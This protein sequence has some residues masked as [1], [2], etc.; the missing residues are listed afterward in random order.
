MLDTEIKHKYKI[1]ENNNDSYLL[2]ILNKADLDIDLVN[3]VDWIFLEN[4]YPDIFSLLNQSKEN[5]YS[6]ITSLAKD[7][8]T[9]IYNK[10]SFLFTLTPSEILGYK[11]NFSAE[12]CIKTFKE[13]ISSILI[14]LD[15]GYFLTDN[16]INYLK[17]NRLDEIKFNKVLD[18]IRLKTIYCILEYPS[19]SPDDRLYSILKK[20]DTQIQLTD[21]HLTFIKQN[22]LTSVLEEYKLQ[23]EQREK[24]FLELKQKYHAIS[25]VETSSNSLLYQILKNIESGKFLKT[26]EINWL[27]SNNLNDTLNIANFITL[28]SKYKATENQDLSLTSHLYK[29][30]QKINSNTPLPETDINFLKKRKL[31]ETIN[32]AL[33]KCASFLINKI[34]LGE[35]LNQQELDWIEKNKKKDVI[36][37][38]KTKHFNKLKEKYEID[39]DDFPESKLYLIL[40]KLDNNQRLD[41]T[42]IAYLDEKYLFRN[43]IYI[44][45]HTIE[46]QFY[47]LDYKKT[48]NK[49]NI[50]NISSHWR[51]AQQPKKALQSTENINFELI[52]EDKLKSAILTTRGGSFRDIDNLNEAEKCAKQAMQFQPSSHHPYTLI[53]AICFDRYQYNEGEKWFAEAIKRGASPNSIDAE[54]KKSIERMK[55]KEKRDKIIKDLLKKDSQRYH[56][57]N[58]YLSKKSH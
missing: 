8:F 38:G 34:S 21:K 22:N 49:W 41:A 26:H 19:V 58:K 28:K 55:D 27:T 17:S 10:Y 45:Y 4:K 18:F 31:T 6:N 40:Q 35:E 5:K 20:L 23:Q 50:P 51:K 42:Q 46:A 24:H 56:W 3:N 9:P 15:S 39:P 33:E 48:G 7:F 11:H 12:N 37:L 57:A 47:E 53:G 44:C 52:K 43:K 16:E 30:L 25:C 2:F 1:T 14:K 13:S 29:V 54:I 36:K 32:I